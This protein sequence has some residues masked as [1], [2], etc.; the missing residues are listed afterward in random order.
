MDMVIQDITNKIAMT[1]IICI[2]AIQGPLYFTGNVDTSHF[3]HH[4]KSGIVHTKKKHKS[5]SL[6]AVRESA[7]KLDEQASIQNFHL[8]PTS[9]VHEGRPF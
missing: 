3:R 9:G 4:G 5:A 2:T 1:E 7:G 8:C 6:Y